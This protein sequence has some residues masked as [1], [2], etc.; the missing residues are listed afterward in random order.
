MKRRCFMTLCV[1]MMIA[2]QPVAAAESS[3]PDPGMIRLN[4]LLPNPVGSDTGQEWVEL[5]NVGTV[6]FDIGGAKIVRGSGATVATVTAGTT[7]APGAFMMIPTTSLLNAGDTLA[8]MLGTTELDRVTY[9]GDGQEGYSWA[10]IDAFNGSWVSAVT[11]GLANPLPNPSPTVSS[12]PSASIPSPGQV[13]INELMPN[14]EGADTGREWIELRNVSAREL[15]IGGLSIRRESG[16]VVAV[17]PTGIR[18]QPDGYYLVEDVEGSLL[19][20]G[21]TLQLWSGSGLLDQVAYDGEGAEGSSW[22]RIDEVTGS[23]TSAP[24]PNS[25]NA[26]GGINDP[27]QLSSLVPALSAT[28]VGSRAATPR[29]TAA[30][31]TSKK[32]ASAKKTAKAS[33]KNLPAAGLSWLAYGLPVLAIIGYGVWRWKRSS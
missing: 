2:L 23:W 30:K 19:N 18:M 12:G 11:P 21:D 29:A 15:E 13:W 6:T 14:P 1:A 32:K 10:R 22:A 26:V 24:T 31:A 17:I 9:D 8:L 5:A 7:L 27:A 33:S 28:T 4:E 3:A 20:S 16:A 25:A